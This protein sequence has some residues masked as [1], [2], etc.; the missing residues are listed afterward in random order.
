MRH[1]L[2]Y[3][4]ESGQ[5]YAAIQDFYGERS[6]ILVKSEQS[7]YGRRSQSRLYDLHTPQAGWVLCDCDAEWALSELNSFVT[8]RLNCSGLLLYV[9]DGDYWAYSLFYC[10]RIVDGFSQATEISEDGL[11]GRNVGDAAVVAAQFPWLAIE[12]IQPYLVQED[13]DDPIERLRLAVPPR[14]GDEYT[15][16][17]ELAVLNFYRLLGISVELRR[18]KEPPFFGGI[19]TFLAPLHCQFWVEET[20]A[21]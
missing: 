14:S 19:V 10:G 18:K 8:K 16:F 9:D 4:V 11:P 5:V 7:N 1:H 12:D 3:G 17:D 21:V 6:R 2:F 20:S 15:R 13:W